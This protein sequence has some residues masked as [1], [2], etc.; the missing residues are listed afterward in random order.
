M[1]LHAMNNAGITA[2]NITT[3]S[4]NKPE[5]R[6][7]I[8]KLLL[9]HGANPNIKL[10]SYSRT[11]MHIAAIYGLTDVVKVLIDH[12]VD[13][14]A[15]DRDNWTPI[16]LAVKH[17]RPKVVKALLAAGANPAPN[18]RILSTT[19]MRLA[20]GNKNNEI[21]KMLRPYF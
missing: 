17:N 19:A 6:A 14:E 9:E 21:I 3:C 11:P 4:E 13:I 8:V 2:L 1:D 16:F 5:A 20:K 7:S 12:R 18:G 15:R 10:S